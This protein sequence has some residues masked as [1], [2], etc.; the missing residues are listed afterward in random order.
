MK[1]YEKGKERSENV[2]FCV[3]NG[4]LNETKSITHST[5]NYLSFEDELGRR[6]FLPR[7]ILMQ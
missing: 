7:K 2:F 6:K 5:A 3:L 4:Q 1:K